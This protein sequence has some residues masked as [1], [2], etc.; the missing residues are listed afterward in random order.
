MKMMDLETQLKLQSYLD[1]ELPEAD[2]AEAAKWLAQNQDAALLM[3]ELRNT[4]AALAGSEAGVRLPESREF[5]WSKIERE[6][7]RREQPEPGPHRMRDLAWLSR[8]LARGGALAGVAVVALFA[9]AQFGLFQ[10]STGPEVESSYSD[11][12]AFSY[13]DESTR[14]TLVWLSYPAEDEPVET[15]P[16]DKLNQL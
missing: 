1:G 13:R 2:A 14:T 9:A 12:G 11:A 10:G 6:I 7:N 5:Y 8:L 4:R 3:A 16:A 15:D